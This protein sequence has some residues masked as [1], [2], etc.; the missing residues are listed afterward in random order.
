MADTKHGAPHGSNPPPEWDAELDVPAIVKGFVWTLVV[1]AAS[2]VV[3]WFG[4]VGLRDW[5]AKNDPPASPLA[6]TQVR[7][8]PA[9]PRLQSTAEADLAAVRAQEA[10]VLGDYGLVDGRPGAAHIPIR[11]A[12]ELYLQQHGGAATTPTHAPAQ[13]GSGH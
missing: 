6:E 4:F 7:L 5:K 3:V 8:V 2:F 1:T 9:E 12:M 11:R 13:E 10:H